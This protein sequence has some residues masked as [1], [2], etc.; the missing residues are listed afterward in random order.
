MVKCKEAVK[1]V[2]YCLGRLSVVKEGCESHLSGT[3]RRGIL[4]V[5]EV[6]C[7]KGMVLRDPLFSDSP[8]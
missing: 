7:R 2:S 6:D 1:Q 4:P 8:I 3:R 5:L